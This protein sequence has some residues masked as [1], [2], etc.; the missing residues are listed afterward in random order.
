LIENHTH[1]DTHHTRKAGSHSH[2]HRERERELYIYIYIYRKRERE[3]EHSSKQQQETI[4]QSGQVGFNARHVLRSW[5]LTK[6]PLI[7][8]LVNQNAPIA[9]QKYK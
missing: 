6:P 2:S 1:T 8:R 4:D 3:R 7:I 9:K 5:F